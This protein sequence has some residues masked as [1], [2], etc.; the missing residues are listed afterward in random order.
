[1][2]FLHYGLICLLSLSVF[3]AMN[4]GPAFASDTNDMLDTVYESLDADKDGKVSKDEWNAVDEDKDGQI[5]ANEWEK[6]HYKS[7]SE[8]T[9]KWKVIMWVDPDVDDYM[10]REEFIRNR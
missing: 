2:R 5:T 8:G 9:S 10:Y 1:M 4:S 6:Y 7:G 3:C